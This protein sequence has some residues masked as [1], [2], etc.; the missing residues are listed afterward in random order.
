MD[1]RV[2]PDA[3]VEVLGEYKR[4]CQRTQDEAEESTVGVS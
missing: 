2:D 4:R 3:V 1:V